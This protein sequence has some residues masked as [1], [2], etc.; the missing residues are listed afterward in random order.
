MV[1]TMNVHLPRLGVCLSGEMQN[2]PR[3]IAPD[4]EVLRLPVGLGSAG[5]VKETGKE[6]CK[7]TRP[8]LI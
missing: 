7:V 5:P 1:H 2:P 6:V 4:G 3:D 8:V